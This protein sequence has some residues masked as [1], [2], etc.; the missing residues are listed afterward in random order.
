MQTPSGDCTEPNDF[1][2]PW[3]S[4]GDSCDFTGPFDNPYTT[5]FPANNGL[6]FAICFTAFELIDWAGQYPLCNSWLEIFNTAFDGGDSGTYGDFSFSVINNC[7]A[8]GLPKIRMDC[9]GAS[10]Y[11]GITITITAQTASV[12][13]GLEPIWGPDI[14]LSA[15]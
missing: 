10:D 3:V 1:V 6:P 4:V 11:T 13:N 2:G 12:V 8:C 9:T 7:E 15:A 5:S 14:V